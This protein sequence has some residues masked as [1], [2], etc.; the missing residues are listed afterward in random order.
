MYVIIRYPDT[1]VI[2]HIFRKHNRRIVYAMPFNHEFDLL[3]VKV[4]ELSSVVDLFVILESNY[5]A[6]GMS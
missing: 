1:I 2:F 3:D 6:A 4:N 5:T